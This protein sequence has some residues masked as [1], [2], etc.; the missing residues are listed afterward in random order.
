VRRVAAIVLPDLACE[1][2]RQKVAVD[3]PL[4][5]IIESLGDESLPATAVLDAADEQ[6]LRLGVRRGQRVVEAAALVAH[7]AVHRVT[8]EE[9][10]A[11]LG[12]VAEVALAFG[13]TV[14]LRLAREGASE[15]AVD[16]SP[17][18]TVWLDVTGAAHL[19]G[20]EDALLEK[21]CEQVFALGHRARA[22]IASGPR[23]AQ[24]LARF[25]AR[26]DSG[27][28]RGGPSGD[29]GHATSPLAPLPVQA[30]PIDPDVSRFLTQIGINTIGD[31]AHLPHAAVAARL[32]PY[33]ADV[34]SLLRGTDD[35]PLLPYEPPRELSEEVVFEEGVENNE[36]LLFV[37]RGMTSRLGVRLAS[38]GEACARL[39]VTIPYD[40]SIAR[41][42]L[43]ERGLS[44]SRDRSAGKGGEG[45]DALSLHLFVDLPA[46]LAE[47][48]DLLRALRAKLERA[49]LIAPAVGLRLALSQITSARRVQLD[50]SRDVAVD[51]D[52]LPALLAELSAEIGPDRVGVLEVV[53]AHR[54]EARSRLVPAEVEG[55]SAGR[56]VETGA[57]VSLADVLGEPGR[58]GHAG[59][60]SLGVAPSEPTRLLPEPVPIG[61]VHPGAVIVVD[62]QSYVIERLRF[63][64]RLQSVE[65]WTP[66]PA[67]RD[68][69]R[70]WLVAKDAPAGKGSHA[71]PGRL[72]KGGA[73]AASSP[74]ST[75]GQADPR[76]AGE[77]WIFVDR[78][79]GEGYLQGWS[80]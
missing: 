61:R 37:L 33:S 53:D 49:E 77:A 35:V 67:S 21:L 25:G 16:D 72:R 26:E 14:A 30:L 80:E 59:E 66:T 57:Q 78:A 48:A 9:I 7:L 52:R 20:G 23:I 1:L 69:A 5:V 63:E 75:D 51:P 3:G 62:G 4:G 32:G 15:G 36:S 41:L 19:F 47:P 34:M 38:R 54:P 43:A 29:R 10:E 79:T 31:L 55:Q 24:A 18:D 65:W 58:A 74:S 27:K 60:V 2:V 13:P 64:M 44:G 50:L 28:R 17:F 56:V 40:R 8:S 39:D 42:R 71:A 22:A 6:A 45:D 68:Y 12:R 11:A 73:H 76:P 70:A 46:P